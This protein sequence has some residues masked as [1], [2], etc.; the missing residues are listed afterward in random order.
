MNT[1]RK[2]V[3]NS[4]ASLLTQVS[5]PA[6]SFVLVYFIAK[7]LGVSGLGIYTSALSVLFISQAFASLGFQQ[8]ITREVAQDNSKASKFFVNASF[9]GFFF[10]IPVAGLMCLSVP[11][12]TDD[13][14]VI[15]AVYVLSISLVPYTL[16]IVCQSI[17]RG[18]EKLEHITFAIVTGNVFKLLLGIFVLF[19]KYNIVCLMFVISGSHLLIFIISLFLT[20]SYIAKAR[21]NLS[22]INIVFCK[23]ILKKTPVFALIII[24]A[25]VR[26]YINIVI[27]TSMMGAMGVGFFSAADRLVNLFSICISFYIFAIQPVIFRLFKSSLEKFKIVCLESIRYFFILILPLIAAITIL[28]D[29]FIVLIFEKE[30]LPSA[31]VL[32]IL[33]WLLLLKGFNQ[34]FANALVASDNQMVNLKANI[35]GMI[36]NIGL[37]LLLIPNLSFIGAGIASTTSAFLTFIYQNHYI[38]RNLFTINYVQ[39]ARKPFFASLFMG[40]VILLFKD[41][42]LIILILIAQIAFILGLL[43]LRTLSVRDMEIIRKVWKDEK[44]IAVTHK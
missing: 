33:I 18:F 4:G 23:W 43:A 12:I 9:L 3:K 41:G 44:E 24:V 27:L 8:L 40:L 2:I 22:A 31:Y 6:T 14:D 1:V 36:S 37:S 35:I 30:F 11:L 38:S 28:G 10:S 29:R 13:P 16:A 42:D 7:F 32:N 20:L 25:A 5:T 21:Q 39:L 19:K 17:S 26:F 34:I 15:K